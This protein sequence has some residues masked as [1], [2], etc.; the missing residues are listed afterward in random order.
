[1]GDHLQLVLPEPIVPVQSLSDSGRLSHIPE[2][3]IIHPSDRPSDI[4]HIAT[5]SDDAGTANI[6]VIDLEGLRSGDARE[7]TEILER[8]AAACR[9][10]GFFQ[11]VNHGVSLELMDAARE[12]CRLGIEKDAVL[13]W[14]DYYFLHYLPPSL[15]DYQKWPA[16]PTSCREEIDE[17][18]KQV[19]ALAGRIMRIMSTNLGLNEDSLQDAFRGD[20]IGACLRV[21]FYPKCPQPD[22]TLGL[23]SHS[24]PG[25][26]TLLLPNS[27][28]AGLQV[29]RGHDWITIMPATH[30][31]IVSMGDQ[32]Q[33]LSNGIYKSVEHRVIVNSSDERISLAFFYNMRANIP[34]GS[35]KELVTYE[36]P[37]LYDRMTFDEYRK[38]IRL[39]G[40]KIP[41]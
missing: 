30:A 37:A 21:N 35:V 9:D 3:Y 1:M 18:G 31:F 23:S 24:D 8:V 28:V 13:N 19:V 25:G 6:P 40:P 38:W 32:I 14:S 4:P 11:V 5:F 7:R 36:R 26:I 12:V 2:R 39:R 29:R 10:W 34:I 33:I 20:D 22:L 15:K 16:L 41:S 17:Y 27:N